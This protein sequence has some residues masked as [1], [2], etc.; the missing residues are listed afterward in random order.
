MTTPVSDQCMPVLVLLLQFRSW[1]WS[2]SWS[3]HFGFVSNSALDANKD[4]DKAWCRSPCAR[5]VLK[6]N[7]MLSPCTVVVN[8]IGRWQNKSFYFITYLLNFILILVRMQRSWSSSWSCS[9]GL[10]L[11][12]VHLVLVLV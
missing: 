5:T 11:D 2:W 8:I 1:S 7:E 9:F 12:L 10:D 4:Y 3:E 6:V